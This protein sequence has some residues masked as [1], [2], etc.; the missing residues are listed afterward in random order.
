MVCGWF[1]QSVGGVA[2]FWMVSSF[3]ANDFVESLKKKVKLKM[4]YRCTTTINFWLQYIITIY[5]Y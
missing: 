5:L 1:G 4:Y 3:A 2:G